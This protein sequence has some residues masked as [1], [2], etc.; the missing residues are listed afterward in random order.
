[1]EA[2][3]IRKFI[4][5][6]GIVPTIN[7]L[8]KM[9]CDNST[10]FLIASEPGVQTGTRHY[11]RSNLLKVHTGAI[12]RTE[13]YIEVCVG[14]IYPNKVIS[15]AENDSI[16]ARHELS[17]EITQSPG[18]SSDTSEGSKN[19]GSFEDNGRSNEE[20]SEDRASSNEGGS[21]TPQVR[22]SSREFRASVRL[23][24]RKKASQSLWMF[25]VKEEQYNSERY[26][27]SLS[28][29]A[30]GA[31]LCGSLELYVYTALKRGFSAS[32]GRKEI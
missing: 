6:L 11:H 10:A 14:A 8:I 28:I 30:A 16:V 2:V 7:E 32:W 17:S 22:R 24:A 3:W 12:Y 25:K 4:S 18:G 20:E 19:S 23:S 29:V 27:A 5:R 1:M 13:V 9:F 31:F 15:K 21:K 26:E